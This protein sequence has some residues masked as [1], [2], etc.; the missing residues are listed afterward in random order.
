MRDFLPLNMEQ[1]AK[2]KKSIL[3]LNEKSFTMG[4]RD[5][6]HLI[7]FGDGWKDHV[8]VPSYVPKE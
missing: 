5:M 3:G 1:I 2:E 4:N 6:I 7:E 8:F